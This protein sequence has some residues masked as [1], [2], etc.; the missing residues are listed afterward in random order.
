VI[1]LLAILLGLTSSPGALLALLLI[2]PLLFAAAL[3]AATRYSHRFMIG[4]VLL[5]TLIPIVGFP[6]HELLHPG[7]L[8]L[9]VIASTG[10]AGFLPRRRAHVTMID[11]A[12][13]V[14]LAGCALSVAYGH[15]TQN[16]L[17]HVFFFWF[18]PYFAARSITGSG[19]RT[20]VLKAFAVAGAV[21]IP[22]GII[23]ITYGNLFLKAFPF[24][25]A[26]QYGIG[27][28]TQRLG[29]TRTEGA[30]GQPI[31][32]AMFL[33]IAAVAAITLWMTR[34]NRRSHRWLYIGLGIV[35]IQATALARTGWLVLAVIAGL[36]IALNFKTIFRYR[37]KRLLVLT[38]IGLA[39]ILAVPKTNAL[40]LGSSGRESVKLEG[41]ADYRSLLIHQALQPGYIDPY[42]TTQRQ[43]GPLGSKSIDDE[44]INA[45]W[46][47]G[48]LPLVG[49]ALMF[50]AFVR[51][52]WR[53]RRDI[54]ALVVYTTCI[55]TMVALVN[56]AFLTQQEVLIWLLWGCASGLTV[57]PARRKL[58]PVRYAVQLPAQQRWLATGTRSS[59]FVEL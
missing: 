2:A 22:F 4:S 33:S 43:I 55:A 1:P 23:E 27:V 24:G 28:S 31:P 6:S 18:C 13:L 35:A 5:L 42:G 40:I 47:W 48:Y 21:A 7:V 14:V 52:A 8:S 56:V 26:P 11:V 16:N 38:A 20:T 12:A 25:S 53:Q 44:Y 30:L 54:V 58:E 17:E 9:I 29:I 41:S 32:Y 37:N 50:L 59:E 49:F 39:V 46:T 19:R 45:A 34:E 3:W 36:V 57:R 10:F 51:G 15:Q